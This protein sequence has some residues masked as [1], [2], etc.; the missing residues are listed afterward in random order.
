MIKKLVLAA[1]LF[2]GL[3]IV[4]YTF[5]GVR[6]GLFEPVAAAAQQ[7]QNA[8]DIPADVVEKIKLLESTNAT[9]RAEAACALGEM[10]Q[11]AVPAIPALI[12]L[13]A[14][15]TS[16]RKV[17][18]G[19]RNWRGG[20]GEFEK[21][22][23]GEQAAE[24]LVLIG[25]PSVEPLVSVIK[26]DDWRVRANATSALGIIKDA[27]ATEAVLVSVKD[28]DWRVREKA[29]WGLGLKRGELINGGIEISGVAGDVRAS[30]INGRVQARGLTGEARLSTINGRL[31]ATFDRL[32]VSK[33]IS[34]N[35]VNGSVA[36]TIPSDSNAELKA[37]TVHGGISNDFGLPVR[38]GKYVG[39]DLSG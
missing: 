26:S 31:E 30:S 15:D 29:A 27:R 14:D 16:T 22:S 19:E 33:A 4:L 8:G 10:K 28:Q 38:R 12:K 13:L 23:P 32:D 3:L 5:E 24:A 6:A 37:N 17:Y 39:R 18:C 20:S 7:Q 1:M 2:S 35:S 21:S 9:E 11:R 25:E 34:L 36:L